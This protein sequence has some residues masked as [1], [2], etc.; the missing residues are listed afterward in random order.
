LPQNLCKQIY[1]TWSGQRQKSSFIRHRK[2]AIKSSVEQNDAHPNDS[3]AL[4]VSNRRE[5]KATQKALQFWP[6]FRPTFIHS[7]M[8]KIL[9]L[10]I[11]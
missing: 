2:K 3:I 5:Q 10:D 4:L 6:T 8:Q 7:I 1:E 11:S 9:S